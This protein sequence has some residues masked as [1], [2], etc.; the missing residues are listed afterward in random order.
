MMRFMRRQIVLG[1]GCFWG[2]Q[3]ILH[4]LE[5]VV[6]TES[7]Y[8]GGDD[9][10]WPHPTYRQ[11]CS[12][13]TGHAEVVKVEWEDERLD[14]KQLLDTF[15]LLHDPTDTG[16]QGPDRGSQYRSI[17]LSERE[18][19]LQLARE[20]IEQLTAANTFGAP[21][22]TQVGRLGEFWS[23]ETYHQHYFEPTLS[24]HGCHWLRQVELP[25]WP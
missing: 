4:A 14:L 6:D 22:A 8:A 10:R 17:I 24:G 16:G 3:A 23:A 9:S 19:D 25:T 18:E 21:I 13:A 12:S 2:V 5:G 11:V 15:L 7:G 20:R 1:G